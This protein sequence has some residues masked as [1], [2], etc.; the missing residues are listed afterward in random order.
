MKTIRSINNNQH[1]L[2]KDII[3]LH[4]PQG[5]IQVDLT[6]STGKFYS[7]GD[8]AEPWIKCDKY[9]I[10]DVQQLDEWY[11]KAPSNNY[12]SIM[13]DP[14]FGIGK[15]PS[16][17]EDN[18]G[19]NIIIKRFNVYG[20]AKEMFD[21][22]RVHLSQCHRLLKD[23]GILIFKCQDTV[24]SGKNYMTH[25]WVMNEAVRQGFYPLDLFVLTAK[26]R[27]ISGKVKKQQHARK[28]HSYFWVFKKCKS[29]VDYDSL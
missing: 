29:K 8:I 17:N 28:Y 14:P 12:F 26:N 15:G 6:Y 27:L 5:G 25:T 4:I 18:D 16:I 24:S 21:S 2:I 23:N 13:F 20:S 9:P 10:G 7:T 19:Q 3:E 1:Q 11:T 22:Y